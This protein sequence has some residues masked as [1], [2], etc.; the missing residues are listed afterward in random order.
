MVGYVMMCVK[1]VATKEEPA[2]SR[3]SLGIRQIVT[4]NLSKLYIICRSNLHSDVI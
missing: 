1:I 3:L 2:L 4:E